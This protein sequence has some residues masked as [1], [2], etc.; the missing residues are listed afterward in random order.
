MAT[1]YVARQVG[2]AGFERL[3][4]VKR[5]HPHLLGNRDFY[6][7]FL[8]E[9]RVASLIHHPNVVP[10]V[11]V[12]ES[13]GELFLVMNYVDSSTLSGLRIAITKKKRRLPPRVVARIIADTLCGL[14]AAHEAVDMRG[15]RLDLVHRDVSPQNIIVGV[16]GISRVID[17]GIAKAAHRITETRT[18]SLKGKYGYMSPE[19][20]KGFALDLRSDIFAVGVVLHEALTGERL[21]A[22][23]NEFET[24]RRIAELQIVDPSTRAPDVPVALDAVVQRSLARNRENRYAT[25]A[26]FMDALTQAIAPASPREVAACL[27]EHCGDRLLERRETLRSVLAGDI[28]PFTPSQ[29]SNF[30]TP[31]PT[32]ER[33]TARYTSFVPAAAHSEPLL[34]SLGGNAA[35]LPPPSNK[36]HTAGIALLV[37]GLGLAV[38]A[39]ATFFL[40]SEGAK[41]APVVTNGAMSPIATPD[42]ATTIPSVQ[43]AA[44]V[45]LVLLADRRIQSVRAPGTKRIE[46]ENK[47]AKVTLEP[48]A[49]TL[50]IDAVLEGGRAARATADA[51]GARELILEAAPVAGT[52]AQQRPRQPPATVTTKPP[53][54]INLAR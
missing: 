22:S 23:E 13:A 48:W 41:P 45:Q 30:G 12:V 3:V 51:S 53:A 16:D 54:D 5:V 43:A 29:V 49:G 38:L 10:V 7:M 20:T 34:P 6:D 15:L 40:Q 28:D 36:R 9:A 37:A 50:T 33:P 18:G 32:T 42:A 31:A 14:H 26:E 46:I 44:E 8:D 19:Q 27:D 35:P 24:M 47:R 4:V 52:A 25:A 2:A 1:V 21:F 17:F 39:S 11:D